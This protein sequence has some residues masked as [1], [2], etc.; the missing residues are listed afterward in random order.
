MS[1][2][3][4][5]FITGLSGSGKSVA[6]NT[7]EDLGYF[8]VDNMPLTLLRSFLELASKNDEVKRIAIACDI[9]DL[10]IEDD[11]REAKELL[12]REGIKNTLLFLEAD[13][14][15]IIKRYSQ[16]RRKHPLSILRNT[17]LK[18][19]IEEEKR[20]MS[21]IKEISDLIVDTSAMSPNDLRRFILSRF[22]SE[23][24]KSFFIQLVSFG[25]KYGIPVESD[26]I[27]DVRFIPNPFFVE[28]LRNATG[29]DEKTKKYVFNQKETRIFL[30]K[31]K[32]LLGLLLPMYQ[33]EA[34]SYLTISVGCTG[35]RHRS[36]V[37]TE[38]LREFMENS[39]FQVHIT[40]RD[41]NK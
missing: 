19:S 14:K 2:E 3:E 31:L 30:T 25:F 4:V 35:G 21:G 24:S 8:C 28:E 32:E 41:I 7:F 23:N 29:L 38:H 5:L 33:K 11:I 39:G 12:N 9:R 34:K 1:V 36:V 16:T 6:L 40:H 37:I 27:F 15:T 20:L 22:S 26:I 10:H 17:T 18:G 13:E